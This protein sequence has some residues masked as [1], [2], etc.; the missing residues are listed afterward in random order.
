MNYAPHRDNECLKCIELNEQ[1]VK[2]T[3]ELDQA[4]QQLRG[5]TWWSA[6]LFWFKRKPLISEQDKLLIAA[7]MAKEEKQET[8][9]PVRKERIDG[10]LRDVINYRQVVRGRPRY[11]EVIDFSEYT[12]YR[13]WV[14]A[15]TGKE[16][17]QSLQHEIT[18]WLKKYEETRAK[19]EIEATRLAKIREA[20]TSYKKVDF[21]A[22]AVARSKALK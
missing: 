6:L 2:L 1:L 20:R 17:E 10:T 22:D 9:I 3:G 19:E 5:R 14:Y 18:V 8:V 11:L 16:V 13:N 15:S 12:G 7:D 4:K 21:V